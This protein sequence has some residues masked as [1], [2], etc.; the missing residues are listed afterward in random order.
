MNSM[1]NQRINFEKALATL[2]S[3]VDLYQKAE[4]NERFMQ[5]E[6]FSRQELLLVLRDSMVH[7]FE[8][9]V[10]AWWTYFQV[11][12]EDVEKMLLPIA[13]PL[14]IIRTACQASVI[15]EDEGDTCMQM[16]ESRNLT[17]HA[18]KEEVAQILVAA[19]PGYCKLLDRMRQR[20]S[21][22]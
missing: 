13:G 20:L 1:Q 11:Y 15:S 22:L 10:D 8:Y 19:L 2:R 3:A 4:R 7:R 21:T 6:P 14:G 18:Y 5:I 16:I 17:P 9:T 12:L